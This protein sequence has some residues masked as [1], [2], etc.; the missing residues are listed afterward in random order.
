M[1]LKPTEYFSNDQ[2]IKIKFMNGDTMPE[3]S[4]INAM[5]SYFAKT[6]RRISFRLFSFGVRLSR[7]EIPHLQ[8]IILKKFREFTLK[9]YFLNLEVKTHE[10]LHYWY[11]NNLE[12]YPILV[13]NFEF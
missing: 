8:F 5:T 9:P 4:L 13:Q 1:F 10:I 2:T 6:E 11:A 12:K 3:I 7:Q